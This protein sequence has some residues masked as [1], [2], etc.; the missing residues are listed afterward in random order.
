MTS[1]TD[2]RPLRPGDDRVAKGGGGPLEDR[3][4]RS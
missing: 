1:A 3:S 4:A 2:R